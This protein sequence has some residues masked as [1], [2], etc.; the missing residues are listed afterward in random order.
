MKNPITPRKPTEP[1]KS[2]EKCRL[3]LD[4]LEGVKMGD[5]QTK[6]IGKLDYMQ[7]LDPE[8]KRELGRYIGR[9]IEDAVFE[10]VDVT[11]YGDCCTKYQIQLALYLID[12]VPDASYSDAKHEAWQKRMERYHDDM[13]DYEVQ[14]AKYNVYKKEKER[15][16]KEREELVDIENAKRLLRKKGLLEPEGDSLNLSYQGR[17]PKKL[18][19]KP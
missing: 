11:D 10:E 18:V 19:D 15:L 1:K 6:F 9:N 12:V 3:V 16:R 17:L 5:I 13:R 8:E 7:W 14:L 4:Y 2:L